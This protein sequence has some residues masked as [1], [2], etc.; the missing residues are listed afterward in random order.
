[1]VIHNFDIMSISI[2]PDEADSPLVID[3]DAMLSLSISFQRLK[4]V[5]RWDEQEVQVRCGVKLDK[6]AESPPLD[7]GRELSGSLPSEQLLCILIQE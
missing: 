4:A 3:P 7:T 1:M 6:F 2:T 5:S